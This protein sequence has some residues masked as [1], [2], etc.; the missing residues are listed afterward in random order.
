MA[1]TSYCNGRGEVSAVMCRFDSFHP[2]EFIFKSF[3]SWHTMTLTIP[4]YN[5]GFKSEKLIVEKTALTFPLVIFQSNRP[6]NLLLH[7]ECI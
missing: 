5:I 1:V 7:Q 3:F 4:P 6:S 2:G